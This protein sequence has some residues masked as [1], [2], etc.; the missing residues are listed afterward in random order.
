MIIIII[1]II[2]IIMFINS[3]ENFES[4]MECIEAGNN[5]IISSCEQ[6]TKSLNINNDCIINNCSCCSGIKPSCIHDHKGVRNC[7]C[8]I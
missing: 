8:Q 5:C 2:I 3:F 6:P 7:I 4:E 1:I